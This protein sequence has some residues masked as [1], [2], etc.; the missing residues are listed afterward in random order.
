M[1]GLGGGGGGAK[2]SYHHKNSGKVKYVCSRGIG[3]PA[4]LESQQSLS[5]YEEEELA[6]LQSTPVDRHKFYVEIFDLL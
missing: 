5:P 4:N 3:S 2:L 6:S 1:R